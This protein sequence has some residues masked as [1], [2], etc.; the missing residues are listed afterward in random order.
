MGRVMYRYVW[1]GLAIV[2]VSLGCSLFSQVT[3]TINKAQETAEA[4]ATEI[5]DSRD[6]LKTAQ[7]LATEVGDSGMIQTAQAL[8]TEVGESG[9]L[10]TAQTF[11]TAQ[12]P[13][14]VETAKAYTT[15]EGS[16]LIQ[17]AQAMI[18]QLAPTTPHPPADVPIVSGEIKI[19]YAQE[20]LI[21]Y[22][23]P[24]P[25]Q[26]VVDF[27]NTQMP[28]QGWDLVEDNVWISENGAIITFVKN[29]WQAV[30]TLGINPI[31]KQ[32]IVLI[33]LMSR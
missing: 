23:T 24:I 22:S 29:D 11:A 3:R 13:G 30:I 5:K 1:G 32:T 21:S 19:F 17:T 4:I 12:G 7:T 15:Q 18:T 33:S 6:L 16:G 31:D 25:I 20:S 26:E 2:A 28:I 9:L 8:A 14:L 10:E 27:Y